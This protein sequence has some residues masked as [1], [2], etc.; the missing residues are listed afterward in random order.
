MINVSEDLHT[1]NCKEIENN[2]QV[3]NMALHYCNKQMCNGYVPLRCRERVSSSS[4]VP[5]AYLWSQT[6]SRKRT[7]FC[8]GTK[9]YVMQEHKQAHSAPKCND[10]LI[11]SWDAAFYT[12]F[13][14]KHS[15]I[16]YFS[17]SRSHLNWES[18]I[19]IVC[20]SQIIWP[21]CMYNTRVSG[22]RRLTIRLA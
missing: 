1:K 21:R 2:L 3:Y 14:C 13:S 12:C 8:T 17:Y 19:Q 16:K 5:A 18:P 15:R 4:P 9:L 22:L 10:T 20:W 7:Q 11:N 6:R